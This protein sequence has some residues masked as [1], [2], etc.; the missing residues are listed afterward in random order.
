MW[1]ALG[2]CQ[3]WLTRIIA[4][5]PQTHRASRRRARERRA[6]VLHVG[7]PAPPSHPQTAPSLT[8]SDRHKPSVAGRHS[9][10]SRRRYQWLKDTDNELNSN[11]NKFK[12]L[13]KHSQNLCSSVSNSHTQSHE[14]TAEQNYC[15]AAKW[16]KHSARHLWLL[17]WRHSLASGWSLGQSLYLSVDAFTQLHSSQNST[18]SKCIHNWVSVNKQSWT[19]SV[20]NFHSVEP[21]IVKCLSS[22]LVTAVVWLPCIYLH[23]EG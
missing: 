1:T 3:L 16:T 18:V 4:I 23:N 12:K 21:E 5:L 2:F 10:Q 22:Y 9:L 17:V 15:T 11:S 14:N 7:N 6:D 8:N 13:K 19:M 20:S